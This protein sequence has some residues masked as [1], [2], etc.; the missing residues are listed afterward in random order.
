MSLFA[1]RE[2]SLKLMSVTFGKEHVVQ[3]DGLL[4]LSEDFENALEA[5]GWSGG[6][7]KKFDDF[8]DRV[9]ELSI[10][11]PGIALMDE[12]IIT[13]IEGETI[14]VLGGKLR[15]LEDFQ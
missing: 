15:K 9:F 6:V 14:I 7:S 3:R 10:A 8:G 1:N 2:V 11:G 13:L 5:Y 12:D 4:Y